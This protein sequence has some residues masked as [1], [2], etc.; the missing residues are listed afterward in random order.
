MTKGIF[1]DALNHRC[2]RSHKLNSDSQK[3]K[4]EISLQRQTHLSVM[5]FPVWVFLLVSLFLRWGLLVSQLARN[6]FVDHAMFLF[7]DISNM[8]LD[9]LSIDSL[10]GQR[11]TR[12]GR[13]FPEAGSG[14]QILEALTLYE[15][16]SEIGG[17][18]KQDERRDLP[19][20]KMVSEGERRMSCPWPAR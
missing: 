16:Y 9:S 6:I 13:G 4:A 17:E 5:L 15:Y 14:L 8:E 11:R 2:P 7:T 3:H 19:P 1:G 18:Y 10:Q 12:M 20:G